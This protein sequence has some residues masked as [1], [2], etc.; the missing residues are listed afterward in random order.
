MKPSM[1]IAA[2]GC[3][4][5]TSR[6]RWECNYTCTIWGSIFQQFRLRSNFISVCGGHSVTQISHGQGQNCFEPSEFICDENAGWHLCSCMYYWNM[7]SIVSNHSERNNTII[8]MPHHSVREVLGWLYFTV[9]H[10][11]YSYRWN[12]FPNN[13]SNLILW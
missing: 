7:S 10:T 4:Q 8:F 2:Q 3:A 12:I 11:S 6:E 9:E 13:C 5:R 1:K